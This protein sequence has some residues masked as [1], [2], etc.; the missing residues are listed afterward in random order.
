MISQLIISQ[1]HYRVTIVLILMKE[2]KSV[3]EKYTESKFYL[4]FKRERRE[5][6][7]NTYT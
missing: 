7:E 3:K 6:K 4:F 2:K 5:R 1:R